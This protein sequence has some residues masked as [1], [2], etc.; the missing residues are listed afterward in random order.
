MCIYSKM[1]N[2]QSKKCCRLLGSPLIIALTTIT[3]C[4]INVTSNNEIISKPYIY[5]TL[6][7]IWLLVLCS[8]IVKRNLSNLEMLQKKKKCKLG[9][10]LS[11]GLEGINST[12]QFGQKLALQTTHGCN[13]PEK[14]SRRRRGWEDADSGTADQSYELNVCYVRTNLGRGFHIPFRASTLTS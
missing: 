3:L 10:F 8:P 14:K 13:P 6:S 9:A 7:R 11:P 1:D 5:K 4:N 2:R 12:V